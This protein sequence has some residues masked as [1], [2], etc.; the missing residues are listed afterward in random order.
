MLQHLQSPPALQIPKNIRLSVNDTGK[1]H[2]LYNKHIIP[3]FNPSP[4]L[5]D[6]DKTNNQLQTYGNP[7]PLKI[8]FLFLEQEAKQSPTICTALL[9]F[10]SAFVTSP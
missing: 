7:Q 2:F 3:S 10:F 9:S 4:V 5:T 1:S 8:F 6:L